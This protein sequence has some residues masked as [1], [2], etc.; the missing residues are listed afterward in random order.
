MERKRFDVKVER[1]QSKLKLTKNH[2]IKSTSK[3]H[4]NEKS[5]R[6]PIKSSDF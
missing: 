4:S 6:E 2:G 3:S 5:P 1:K